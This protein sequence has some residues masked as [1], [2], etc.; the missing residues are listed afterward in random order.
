MLIEIEFESEL[1]IY[2]QIYH[3]IIQGI[4]RGELKDGEELPSVRQLSSDIG[5][6]KNTVI[7]AYNLLKRDGIIATH[8]RKGAVIVGS[9]KRILTDDME[10]KIVSDLEVVVATGLCFQMTREQ[11]EERVQAILAQYLDRQNL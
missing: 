9:D 10:R 2:T 4:S 6:D 1:P 5:V 8:R 11:M 7:K 3:Q